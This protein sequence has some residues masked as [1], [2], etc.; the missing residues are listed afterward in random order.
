MDRRTFF[1]LGAASAVTPALRLTGEMKN[2]V[3]ITGL[4]TD[5]LRFPPGKVYYDAIHEFGSEGGAV[6]LRLQTDAGVTGW[7]LTSFGTVQ[8]GPRVLEAILQNE[9]KAVLIGKDP[10]FPKRIRAE[11]WKALEYSGVQGV[12]A[13]AIAA[14][15]IAIW[16]IL[17]KAAQMPVYKML[18]AYSSQ[19]PVY[20]MCGWYYPDDQDLSQFKRSLSSAFEEGFNAV[21]IKVG[22]DSMEDDERR[23]KTAL[24]LAGKR[25]V[26]VDA[27][28]KFNVNEAILRGKLY[29]QM[30]CFWFE[31]PIVPYDHAGYARIAENLEIQIAAGENEYTKYSFLDLISRHGIDVVQPD[32]R[33][34]GGVSEWM[35]IG[36]IADS[37][38]L[39]LASHGG[40]P[41]DLHMLLAMPNA[42]YME[43]GS[44]KGN[45]STV[46][47]LDMRESAIL[48]PEQPGIGSELRPDY[49]RKYKI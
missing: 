30:G 23:I 29:Q 19:V 24:Q 3:R 1:Q 21:K 49:I 48:A 18:G 45:S 36:A 15:D 43:M 26:M 41:T 28:Q 46:E 37:F 31:E 25:R 2:Q 17:G 4:E 44:L 10:S 40:G 5:V 6:V 14:A 20:S 13:F 16:D 22:R 9:V 35:E 32:G 12:A 7:A 39:P 38:G 8:G 47:K 42:I 34:A 27:N 33:R 11:L